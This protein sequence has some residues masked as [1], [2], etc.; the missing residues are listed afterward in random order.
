[1]AVTIEPLADVIAR[2]A[3]KHERPVTARRRVSP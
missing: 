3:D 1:M 2:L